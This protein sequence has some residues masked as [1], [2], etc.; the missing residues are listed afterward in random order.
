MT[1]Q[2]CTDELA[3]VETNLQTCTSTNTQLEADINS[4]WSNCATNQA[5][6]A[7]CEEAKTAAQARDAFVPVPSY[8]SSTSV[9]SVDGWHVGRYINS[10]LDSTIAS[11]LREFNNELLIDNFDGTFTRTC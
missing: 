2:E 11:R 7:A 8:D 6:G 4:C 10:G 1:Y 9:N 5:A 3:Q